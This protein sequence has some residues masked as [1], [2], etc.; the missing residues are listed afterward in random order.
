MKRA[1]VR[2]PIWPLLA[3]FG[4]GAMVLAFDFNFGTASNI[5]SAIYPLI[6]SS[7]IVLISLFSI[8]FGRNGQVF[9]IDRRP[10]LAVVS[11]VI[12][13]CLV[14]ERFGVVPAV[15]LCMIVAYA[16]QTQGNYRFIF[17]YAVLFAFGTWALF[18]YGL[19]LPLPTFRM[20]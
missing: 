6:L 1:L 18:S 5:G 20:P 3:V 9:A 13:F 12:L 19:G 7:A 10:F 14:V 15:V 11:S 8:V 2:D 16:G 4:V 17:L